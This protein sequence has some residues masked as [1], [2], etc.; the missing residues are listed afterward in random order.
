[1]AQQ[2]KQLEKSAL[3]SYIVHVSLRAKHV[4]LKVSVEYGVEVVVPHDFDHSQIP[5]ILQK[6]QTWL[7]AAN[8]R[9]A[10]YRQLFLTESSTQ[11]PESIALRA[12]DEE[13]TVRYQ[14]TSSARISTTQQFSYQLTVQGLVEDEAACRLSL[15]R[16]MSRKAQEHL[17]PWLQELSTAHNLS[18]EKALIRGQKTRWASC[19]CLKTI[20][21]NYKLLFLPPHLVRYV[22]IHELSHTV[23][24]N[25]SKQFWAFVATLDPDYKASDQEL[26]EAWRY[27][28]LWVE[29]LK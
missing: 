27:V 14:T 7:K 20:S 8:D 2:T 23:H 15:R 6:K 22:L 11:L 28:P 1:M 13:W 25:H 3:P 26:K 18:F 9:I 12:L 21:L 29:H 16:W 10:Q 24:L 4:R 5:E 17:F 19:S